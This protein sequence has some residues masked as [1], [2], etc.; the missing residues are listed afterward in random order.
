[1]V[2][3]V[4]IDQRERQGLCNARLVNL[5]LGF[6]SEAP[7]LHFCRE[8]WP[9]DYAISSLGILCA[10]NTYFVLALQLISTSEK[11]QDDMT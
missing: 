4:A 10:G 6:G 7:L 3:N 2:T 9:L 8:E 1:M 11:T 5:P